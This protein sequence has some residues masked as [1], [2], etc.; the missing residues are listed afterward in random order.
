ME[1]YDHK[2]IEGKWQKL[3]QEQGTYKQELEGGKDKCYVLNEFPYPSGEG[4]HVGHL[5]GN[6]G[7]DIYSRYKRMKGFSVLHPMGW[8]AFGLP[9]ENYA[10]KNKVHPRIAAEK[11]VANFKSQL[12]KLGFDFDWSREVNTTDPAYYKWT[13]WIFLQMFKKGLAYES[14]EPINWCPSCQTG[15]ANE[16]LE[17]GKC[18]RCGS[19][20]EKK[21]IRQWVLAITKY[22]DRLLEDLEEL[23]WPEHIKEM[24]RAWIGR[25]DGLIFSAK[26]KDTNIEVETFSAHFEACF[27]DTF[28]V[29][30]PDHPLLAKLIVGVSNE[31][32]IKNKID[33]INIRRL[34]AGYK[35]GEVDGVFT[36]RYLDD[37]LGNGHLPIWVANYALSDYGTGIVKCSA[38]DPRDFAFAAKFEIPLKVVLVPKDEKLQEGVKTFKYCYSDFKN[39]ILLEP[40]NLSGKTGQELRESIAEYVVGNGWARRVTMYRLRDW[41]FSRQRYWGEPI[42][43]IHCGKSARPDGRSGGCGVVAVPDSELPVKLPEVEHYEPTGTGESPLANIDEWVNVKCPK[44][45]G[46]AKRETNTMPQW[47][48]SSWYW[49]RYM[50]P[51]NDKSFVDKKI[52][53]AWSPVDLYVGGSEH[54]TRHLIYARFWHKFLFDQDLVSTKEPFTKRLNLGLIL[55]ADGRKISKRLGNGVNPNDIVDRFG[56]D[57]LRLYVMF[58]GPFIDSVAWNDD[59]IIG[60]R[61]FLERVWRLVKTTSAKTAGVK[62]FG[63]DKYIKKVSQDIEALK[64]NTAVSEL[65]KLLN[66]LEK[67]ET[68]NSEI[69]IFLKLL[70]PFAPHLAEELWS[71]LAESGSV[72]LSEWPEVQNDDLEKSTSGVINLPVQIDGKVRDSIFIEDGADE[73]SVRNTALQSPTVKKWLEGKELAKVVYVPGRIVNVVTK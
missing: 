52:E 56:A 24:Q 53:K 31:E 60:P 73:E 62:G 50:D 69:K 16:D 65:M 6:I 23:D 41:V 72:H 28:V 25:S 22:A 44:C 32:E 63:V 59:A 12:G 40:L 20:V 27:A 21:R 8:D 4:L 30:A 57:T 55:G 1:P 26:V 47:A 38:H 3:W 17:D 64:F 29:I 67:S 71:S 14:N 48:G 18:E 15:L 45:G 9:A 66:E 7:T 13:Q 33:D 49:L 10:I 46:E 70:S 19:V 37:P 36:G 54:T 51:H 43:L 42:P 39:G 11:N 34:K 35:E 61:R 2:S 68:G 5:R 58:I